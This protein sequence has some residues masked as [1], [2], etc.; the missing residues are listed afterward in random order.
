V[1]E[2]TGERGQNDDLTLM[3]VKALPEG[4]EAAGT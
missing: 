4:E 3:V 1:L 2:W